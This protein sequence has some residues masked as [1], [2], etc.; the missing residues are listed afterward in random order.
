LAAA[1][2]MSNMFARANMQIFGDPSTMANM[3][4]QFMRA[5]SVGNAADGL[6]KTLPDE[7]KAMLDKIGSAVMAQLAP[8]DVSGAATA[9]A[10]TNGHGS[11]EST[12]A[13]AEVPLATSNVDAPERKG[14]RS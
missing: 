14:R 2:A 6:L 12:A 1:Q 9:A 11:T 13:V 7:G 10:P 8:K 5:A 4:M 3:S